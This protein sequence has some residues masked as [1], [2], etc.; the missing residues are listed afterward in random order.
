M[1]RLEDLHWMAGSWTA[2]AE[3]GRHDEIWMPAAGGM[4]L[5][6]HRHVAAEAPTIYEYLR[7]AESADGLTYHSSARGEQPLEFPLRSSGEGRVVFQRAFPDYPSVVRY[8]LVDGCLR[9]R[10]E[11]IHRGRQRGLEWTLAR[12]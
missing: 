2:Q 11:G 1:S 7:I 5:G 10:V 3:D 8:R 6:A 9:L 4:M 12:V